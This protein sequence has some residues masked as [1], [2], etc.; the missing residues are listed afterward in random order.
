VS[1]VSFDLLVWDYFL[2]RGRLMASRSEEGKYN[3][4]NNQ[5]FELFGV[6]MDIFKYFLDAGSGPA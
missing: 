2:D 6:F 4:S 1:I 3:N 5:N